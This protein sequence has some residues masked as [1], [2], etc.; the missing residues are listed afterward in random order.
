M[1]KNLQANPLGLIRQEKAQGKIPAK[2]AAKAEAL[3]TRVQ[4]EVFETSSRVNAKGEYRI[5]PYWGTSAHQT[6]LKLDPESPPTKSKP[7]RGVSEFLEADQV[8]GKWGRD[9]KVAYSATK[10]KMV[11][12]E[13]DD[14]VRNFSVTVNANGTLTIDP[15]EEIPVYIPLD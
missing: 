2:L 10:D 1:V 3:V 8:F 15:G 6:S 4:K 12:K 7:L 14:S 5:S 13:T 11:F 9:V